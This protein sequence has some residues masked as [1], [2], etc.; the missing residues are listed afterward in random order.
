MK[1]RE[2]DIEKLLNSL[3]IVDVVSEVVEL[4]K[5]GA[6]YK[7]LCP[8]HSD[9]SPSFTVSPQKNI[10]K[11]F[12][13]G[14]GGNP[15][16][17]YSQYHKIGFTEACVELS[18]K[19]NID[20]H[21]DKKNNNQEEKEFEKLYKLMEEA[22][23]YFSNNIFDNQ[24]KE[25]FEYLSN[26]GLTA[27]FIKE[28]YIGF[29]YNSWDKLLN[30][31]TQKG[32]TLED[33]LNVGLIKKGDKG[34][35]DTFRNR[36]MFPITNASG[37]TIAFGGRTLEDR[38]DIAKY[39]NSSDTVLFNKRKNL[40]G[41][42]EK[43]TFIRK[44]NYSILM[45]GYMDVLKA[46]SFGF[47]TAIASLGTAFTSEQGELLKRYSS[48][49]IIAYDMD[50]AG[51]KAV[52]RTGLILKEHGFNIRVIHFEDAKDPDEYL[53]KFGK[54]KFLERVKESKEI[55]DFLLEYYSREYDLSNLIGKQNFVLAFKPFFSVLE[56]DIEK[57]LYLG[58]LAGNLDIDKSF[59][60]KELIENNK[61][62]KNKY[63]SFDENKIVIFEKKS[64]NFQIN[65][66]EEESLK[67]SLVSKEFL[68]FFAEKDIES[69]FV[70]KIIK[71]LKDESMLKSHN[72]ATSIMENSSLD[73]D[74]K[75]LVLIYLTSSMTLEERKKE[76][77]N[78]HLFKDWFRLEIENSMNYAKEVKN[79]MFHYKLKLM[80]EKLKNENEFVKNLYIDFKNLVKEEANER[81]Y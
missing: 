12:S 51:Q 46:H 37:K 57:A 7:G 40:Y 3:K 80:L 78:N 50:D 4:K 10:A 1:V 52:E 29:S 69:S 43:G 23:D 76:E 63:N 41:F 53:N 28:N 81:V 18:K 56:K 47:D 36:I 48:N 60:E 79:P 75:E 30:D 39:L 67:L 74:E 68:D 25:A 32:Y 33:L 38:K 19:Y 6:N 59:L 49:V 70:K 8:F 65:S 44:K 26:R 45:E 31:F 14:A 9:T 71:I 22:R 15:I 62:E 58:K 13:C 61:K 54:D 77:L 2:D 20:I 55:F 72:Y 27:Q 34:Y 16:S 21:Y 5:S 17:F 42:K 64:N 35:Y 24:G 73:E 11:C 66:L